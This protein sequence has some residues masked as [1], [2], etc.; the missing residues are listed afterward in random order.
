[1]H[2]QSELWSL[3][4]I[5]SIHREIDKRCSLHAQQ[6]ATK[7]DRAKAKVETMKWAI[8]SMLACV[9]LLATSIKLRNG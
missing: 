1:M 3:M 9:G 7:G 4:Q 8:A 5:E 6:L 2:L